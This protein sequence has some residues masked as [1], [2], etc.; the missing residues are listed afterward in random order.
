MEKKQSCESVNLVFHLILKNFRW[1][2]KNLYYLTLLINDSS[3][4]IDR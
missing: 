4:Q 3:F 2:E 1:K